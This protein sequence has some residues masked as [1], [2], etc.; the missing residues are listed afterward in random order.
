MGFV[1]G[2]NFG[3]FYLEEQPLIWSLECLLVK[4]VTVLDFEASV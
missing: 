1:F 4:G 2:E 3:G